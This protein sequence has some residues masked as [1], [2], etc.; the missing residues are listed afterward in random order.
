MV[1]KGRE[2]VVSL[3]SWIPYVHPEGSLYFHHPEKVRPIPLLADP[4]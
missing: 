3:G 2:P 4:V 1:L